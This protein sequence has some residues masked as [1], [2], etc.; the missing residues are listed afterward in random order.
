M[1]LYVY[2]KRCAFSN[3]PERLNYELLSLHFDEKDW[4]LRIREP[5]ND[6]LY[7]YSKYN[8]LPFKTSFQFCLQ[9]RN[10]DSR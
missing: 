10:V 2:P 4:I 8:L 9:T 1:I 3:W 7:I 5:D 6:Q